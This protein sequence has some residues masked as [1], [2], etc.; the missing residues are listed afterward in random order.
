MTN[1]STPYGVYIM[2]YEDDSTWAGDEPWTAEIAPFGDDNNPEIHLGELYSEGEDSLIEHTEEELTTY[3]EDAFANN[4]PIDLA[5]FVVPTADKYQEH[6]KNGGYFMKIEI[7]ILDKILDDSFKAQLIDKYIRNEETIK[8]KLIEGHLKRMDSID[9]Y[10]KDY[11]SLKT[12]LIKR[13]PFLRAKSMLEEARFFFHKDN[14]S[15]VYWAESNDIK[16]SNVVLISA[17]IPK[18]LA[19]RE[20][21]T[22][23]RDSYSTLD[24]S[25]NFECFLELDSKTALGYIALLN[26]YEWLVA[27][28]VTEVDTDGSL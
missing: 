17:T 18:P 25:E 24:F 1:T 21:L 11:N 16:D 14:P 23:S 19:V 2:V 6:I 7:P 26:V 20:N 12:I 22:F 5:M 28:S 9:K 13:S 4:K 8:Q 10:I 15:T 27:S 3:F